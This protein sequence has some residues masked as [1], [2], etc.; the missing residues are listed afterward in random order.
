MG[1]VTFETLAFGKTVEEAFSKAVEDARH[2]HGHGGYT[3]T[4]AEKDTFEVIPE[5]GHKGRQKR[6]VARELIEEGDERIQSKRGPAGAINC[7]GTTEA[8]RYRER[9]GLKGKHGDVWL[10]F[11]WASR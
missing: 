5:R 10:F 11:G 8:K 6:T 1:A 7:S 2:T 4:I 9:K 3:G